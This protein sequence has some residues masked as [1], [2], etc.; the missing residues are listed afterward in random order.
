MATTALTKAKPRFLTF[1]NLI[2]YTE[3]VEGIWTRRNLTFG[4]GKNGKPAR[5]N[6]AW[7]RPDA[8]LKRYESSDWRKAVI[9]EANE[10]SKSY[11]DSNGIEYQPRLM[12]DGYTVDGEEVF[13]SSMEGKAVFESLGTPKIKAQAA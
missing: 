4:T 10:Y 11:T 2:S 8:F 7:A 13:K 6:T 5:F 12:P 3:Y 9:V 1:K